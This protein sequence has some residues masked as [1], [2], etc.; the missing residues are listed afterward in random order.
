MPEEIQARLIEEEMKQS[1]MDYAMSVIVARA[2]PD[3]RDGLKP[4]H[5][6]I[7]YAMFREGLL[8]NK[9][10]SKCAGVVGETLKKYHPHG[11]SSVYD[12]LVR[13]AQ[14]WNLRY[15]LI[16][17]HG[18]FGNVD[19]DNA[20]AYRYTECRLK[21]IAEELLV[22]ID[23]ETV[24]FVDNFDGTTQEPTVLP[25]KIP[26]LLVN[27]SSG[28]AVGMA[29]NIPPHN[30]REVCQALI[31]AID[32]RDC[33]VGDL[34]Q[35]VKGPDF[36]TGGIIVGAQGIR[37]AYHTGKGKIIVR[38]KVEFEEHK[39]IVTEI[40]YMVN[41]SL[42]I[43]NIADLVRDKRVE[44]ISDIRDESD[45]RGIRVVLELKRDA[46]S[47]IV[48]N[49]LYM[50]SNLQTTF[51]IIFLSLVH[52]EPKVLHLKG[53]I[54]EFI[55]HRKDVLTK[56]T[57]FDLRKSEERAHVLEGLQ[58]ALDHIDSVIH[59]IKQSQ[60]VE[61]ARSFLIENYALSEIQANA[62]LDMKLQRLTSLET[63]KIAS[64]YNEIVKLIIELKDIL[65]HEQKI[66]D[67]IKKD[68]QEIMEEYGDE[69]KTVFIDGGREEVI[70]DEDL[71]EE[72][73]VVI[74]VTQ[75]G[76]I[77]QLPL[78]TYKSQ[79][80]GGTGVKGATVK[81]E[82]VI[83]SVFITSNLNYLLLFTNK[84]KIHWL[85]AYK[86][87]EASR[88]AK[89][90]NLVNL[91]RLGAQES[92]STVLP[93]KNL[94]GDF[95]LLFCTKK[96]VVKK[97]HLREFS[98]PRQGGIVAL[99]LRDDDEVI[100]VKLSNGEMNFILATKN[101]RAVKFHERDVREMGRTATGV[102]GVLL[103]DDIVTGMEEARDD[104]DLLTVTENGFGKRTK[105]SE[106]RLIN[107]GGKGVRN[108]KVTEKNGKVVG[109]KAVRSEDDILCVT[110]KG[111]VIRMNVNGISCIGRN[112]QGVRLVRLREDDKVAKVTKISNA[113]E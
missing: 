22:D 57:Q 5:R 13:M 66:Y 10:Y 84:G 64:E 12:A 95:Y 44:G 37:N 20:A 26:N 23:K 3:I 28:I 100:Q 81:E 24:Q 2:I 89:G 40:P 46:Q 21:K 87:P 25:S 96:G 4:V 91:L 54:D 74:T 59:G 105:I 111:Q 77:K 48:L 78:E 101:G 18:N 14:E 32:H 16:D 86:V 83:D 72:E 71:I 69:R 31:Y 94:E 82:D 76:Y 109:V 45:R 112:T 90:T 33:T 58:I 55:K 108:I 93:V 29:T 9:K 99:T 65:A 17:G 53:I 97:T 7:L 62:I 27:G 98:N 104:E 80:R 88:Y 42:L 63:Q 36:P 49:Q 70:T 1:Y 113:K 35:F 50:M 51:G 47:E 103:M 61:Q 106:Y 56:R 73:Q 11:D 38:S 15:K 60:S 34:L 6:R 19:G 39:I 8:H 85:K 102:R 75:N 110:D 79:K 68:L 92:V 107:R 43:E 52:N 41:K 30:L 67:M